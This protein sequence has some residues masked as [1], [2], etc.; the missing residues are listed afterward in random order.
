MVPWLLITRDDR[1]TTLTIDAELRAIC[2]S[3]APRPTLNGQSVHHFLRA[4]RTELTRRRKENH[5]ERAKQKWTNE[6][7]I[8]LK[9][10]EL[11]DWLETE[12]DRVP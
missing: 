1:G 6:H 7:V 2:E 12:L 11:L 9:Q 3:R 8:K 5:D 4:L 10:S